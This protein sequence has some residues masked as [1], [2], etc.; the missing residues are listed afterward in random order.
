MVASSLSEM[1]EMDMGMGGEF[2]S[3]LS[4]L[5]L[6]KQITIGPPVDGEFLGLPDTL[7]FHLATCSLKVVLWGCAG[8]GFVHGLLLTQGNLVMAIDD[9]PMEAFLVT[10]PP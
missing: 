9:F 2:D 5:S 3:L 4:S 7:L 1:G 10:A 8:I 6:L